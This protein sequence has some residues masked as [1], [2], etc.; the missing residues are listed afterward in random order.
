MKIRPSFKKAREKIKKLFKSLTK[1]LFCLV[2]FFL[3]LGLLL[4]LLIFYQ[5]LI[6]IPPEASLISKRPFQFN[7]KGFVEVLKNYEKVQ[8]KENKS[9]LIINSNPFRLRD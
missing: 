5:Y 9:D 4:S 2:L 8:A 7:E 1:K 3:F 6:L